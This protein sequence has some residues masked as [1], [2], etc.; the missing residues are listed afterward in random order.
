MKRA[1]LSLTAAAAIALSQAAAFTSQALAAPAP[2]QVLPSVLNQMEQAARS[3]TSLQAGITQVKRDRTLD[4][5]DTS[6][7]TFYYKK[8]APGQDRILL[9]YT[10]PA[11]QT[12]AVVGDKVTIY[13]PFINQ[14][15]ETTRQAQAGKNKSLSFLGL[16]YGQAAQQL[17]DKFTVTLLGDEVIAGKKTTLLALRPKVEENGIKQIQI[18]VDNATWLPLQY[19][20][21]ERGAETTVSL[22]AMKPNV[23]LDDSKFQIKL[24]GNVQVV[25]G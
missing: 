25:K 15:I 23:K 8:G 24:P 10:K 4:A 19:V 2:T 16:G 21:L 20:L 22:S 12:I 18:W 11:P 5:T 13:Q 17:R 9:E 14:A 1:L 6:A 3:L 7:G